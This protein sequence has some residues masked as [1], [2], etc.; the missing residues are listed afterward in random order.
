MEEVLEPVR[1]LLTVLLFLLRL[2]LPPVLQL[3]LLLLL[4][5]LRSNCRG[6]SLAFEDLGYSSEGAP[7]ES[8]LSLK[9]WRK[10]SQTA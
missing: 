5:L 3:L 6:D 7:H 1:L 2:L 8:H 10:E 9:T 4:Q